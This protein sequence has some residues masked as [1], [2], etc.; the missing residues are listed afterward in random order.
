MKTSS[1]F[2]FVLTFLALVMIIGLLGYISYRNLSDYLSREPEYCEQFSL[3]LEPETYSA[4]LEVG[5]GMLIKVE[6]TNNGFEDEFRIGVE[7]PDWVATRPVK[8]RL[9]QGESEQIFVYMSPDIGSEGSYT[10]TVFAKSY[11]G[12]EET[13]I[14]IEV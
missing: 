4:E 2:A 9:D 5:K 7:G 12:R 6:I 14:K 13:E 8:I 1:L 10:L 11:C 3:D